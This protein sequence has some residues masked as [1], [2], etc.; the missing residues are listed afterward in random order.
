MASF[1]EWEQIK[2]LG[3]GGQSQ[4]FLV[5]RPS[6]VKE[7]ADS[8]REISQS[9]PWA[10]IVDEVDRERPGR[11]A[12][13]ILNYARTEVPSEL[14]ALKVFKIRIA[15]PEGEQRAID[16]LSGEI[17]ILRGGRTGLPRLLDENGA[18]RWMVT[19]FF[20][21]GTLEDN[22]E[23]YKGK[24][25]LALRAFRSLVETVASLHKD[26]IVHRDIK[27]A[28]VFIRRPDHLV[29]GDFGIVFLPDIEARLTRTGERVGPWDYMPQWADLGERLENVRTNFDVYMLGKLLWCLVAGRLRLPR[30]YHR[31]QEFDLLRIFPN[32]PDMHLLNKISDRCIVEDPNTCLESA[33]ELLPLIDETIAILQRGGQLIA[34][35]VP[36]PCRVCG[37]GIYRRGGLG[38]NQ[39]DAIYLRAYKLA[40]QSYDIDTIISVRPFTCDACGHVEFFK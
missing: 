23:E 26:G 8:I 35:E 31:R 39:P 19:E 21:S 18:E 37:K 40:R 28:N 3:E 13:A 24:P 14:G 1:A 30:E 9:N 11:L 33:Q 12:A 34:N 5:R 20:P 2:L 25:A 32:D 36:R 22:T 17:A 29:L 4:V 7:R 6:R 27:P 16:R 10:P 38:A 15:G